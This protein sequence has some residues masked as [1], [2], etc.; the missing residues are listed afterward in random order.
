MNKDSCS[1]NVMK[2]CKDLGLGIILIN[3]KNEIALKSE[4][5]ALPVSYAS[6]QF[7]EWLLR[8][9]YREGD[10]NDCSGT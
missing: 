8:Y 9:I 10:S 3:G 7:N 6:I 2:T 1:D 5:R 4:K